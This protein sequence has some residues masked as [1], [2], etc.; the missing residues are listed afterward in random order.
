MNSKE[1]LAALSKEN[2]TQAIAALER[3][4]TE[5]RFTDDQKG[6]LDLAFM[7]IHLYELVKKEGRFFE[8]GRHF[9]KAGSRPAKEPTLA[10]FREAAQAIGRIF[11]ECGLSDSEREEVEIV[12]SAF[13]Q[14]QLLN[15]QGHFFE[16]A[17]SLL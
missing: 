2:V 12:L 7:M 6:E 1:I 8:T 3:I 17:K 11:A 14:F 4:Y 10:D 15:R 5:H 9:I 13:H 16:L